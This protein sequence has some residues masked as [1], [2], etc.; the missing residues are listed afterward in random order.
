MA[1]GCVSFCRI[2]EIIIYTLHH[3]YTFRFLM[4]TA[5]SSEKADSVIIHLLEVMA[6]I[7]IPAEIKT[8]NTPSYVS[9][10]MEYFFYLL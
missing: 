6:I 4:S 7:S 3:W 9:K 8:N 5:F 1:D 10:K 2:L